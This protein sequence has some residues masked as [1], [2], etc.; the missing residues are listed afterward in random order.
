MQDLVT[1][2][3]AAHKSPFS[4][5]YD[6][7]TLLK[8]AADEITRLRTDKHA[9]LWSV[10]KLER[11]IENLEGRGMDWKTKPA[12]TLV[13]SDKATHRAK[14][15]ETLGPAYWGRGAAQDIEDMLRLHLEVV[16]WISEATSAFASLFERAGM[17]SPKQILAK[18]CNKCWHLLPEECTPKSQTTPDR[19]TK[20]NGCTNGKC[21]VF[22]QKNMT[23]TP[24]ER[25]ALNMAADA[26]YRV[27][28]LQTALLGLLD[29]LED[30]TDE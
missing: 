4:T 5:Q 19:C 6:H 13:V 3:R 12:R 10:F 30:V 26:M 23:L 2:L 22:S 15:W 25:E 16:N 28:R 27:P 1:D 20:P 24:D 29:R 7:R 17:D 14:K 21:Q 9:L 8:K 11:K 18:I